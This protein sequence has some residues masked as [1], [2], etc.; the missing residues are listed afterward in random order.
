MKQAAARHATP[1]SLAR[2]RATAGALTLAFTLTGCGDSDAMT[3]DAAGTVTG[4]STSDAASTT[5]GGS[6]SSTTATTSGAGTSTAGSSGASSM[7]AATTSQTT[8]ATTAVTTGASDDS[9][10]GTTGL[11][12]DVGDDTATGGFSCPDNMGM[13]VEFS[14]IWISNTGESTLS[15][16]NT[17][18]LVEEGRYL[19]RETPGSPSRTSVNLSGDVVVANR[20][21]GVS[22]F[23]ARAEDCVDT[24][25]QP[26]IQTSSGKDD[27]LAWSVEECRAWFT[28]LEG[29]SNRPIAWTSGTLNEQTCE[30]EDQ[31]VWTSTSFL[32]QPGTMKVHRLNGDTGAVEDVVELPQVA[33]GSW[34]AYGGA[35]DGDNNLWMTTHGSGTLIRVRD[36]DLSVSTWPAPAGVLTYGITVDTNGRPWVAGFSG[37]VA[38]FDP[39]LESWQVVDAVTGLGLQADGEGRVWVG[40]YPNKGVTSIDI[41][42]LEVLDI[43]P[44]A[45]GVT[46]GVSVDFFGY[47]W[48][49]SMDTQA[50]RVDPETQ[51]YDIYDGLNQAYTYSDMTGWGLK[52]VQVPQ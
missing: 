27:V 31:K 52:N 5:A 13:D 17:Q 30:W 34:G 45:A 15:K 9:S 24:N 3:S 33:L 6:A 50:Y 35:V 37:G 16:L 25:G 8:A 20:S 39:E 18:T 1:R 47:V 36:D 22:K 29:T 2:T 48:V 11:K 38:R 19:T 32:G 49:V 28:Q 14:Y 4:P 41:E 21:G 23:Y 10:S 44:I 40:S 26:G 43:I 7:T 12:L 42:T 46:K 51:T